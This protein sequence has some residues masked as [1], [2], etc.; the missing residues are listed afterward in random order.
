MKLHLGVGFSGT[1]IS[2]G[3]KR[4]SIHL[5]AQF[6]CRGNFWTDDVVLEAVENSEPTEWR[7]NY[8]FLESLDIQDNNQH[9]VVENLDQSELVLCCSGK[10][11]RIV[12]RNNRLDKL[13]IFDRGTNTTLDLTQQ[14]GLNAAYDLNATTKLL[15]HCQGAPVCF[16]C[17]DNQA[18]QAFHP[19][20]H[21]GICQSCSR[22]IN[23]TSCPICRQK[24]SRMISLF[25]V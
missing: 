9:I 24:T 7:P 12:L 4:L 10:N 23:S 5:P 15:Q 21:W 19:C 18:S 2:G 1:T 22:N 11:N 3:G 6:E 17:Q 16:C 8:P 14:G 20:G 25:V 13:T